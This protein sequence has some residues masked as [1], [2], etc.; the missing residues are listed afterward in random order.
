MEERPIIQGYEIAG[1]MP[2]FQQ[3]GRQAIRDDRKNQTR[4]AI[5]PQPGSGIE[6]VYHRPDGKWIW[7]HLPKGAGVGIGLPFGCPYG[8][9]GDIR[10]MTEPLKNVAGWAYYVDLDAEGVFQ[11]VISSQTGKHLRWRWKVQVLSS[12]FMPYEAA[13]TLT[14]YTNVRVE[15]LQEILVRDCMKEGVIPTD[16]IA[17]G[18]DVVHPVGVIPL[19]AELVGHDYYH[20]FQELWDSLNAKRGYPY[21]S[22]P[23]VWVIEFE[24]MK[25]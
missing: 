16:V 23:R 15:R 17:K 22:D 4:R 11:P 25:S 19:D 10:V 8:K 18:S 9:P 5:K 3:W 13:R 2:V 1:R 12:L 24:R 6:D 21:S 20:P 14:R 7:L